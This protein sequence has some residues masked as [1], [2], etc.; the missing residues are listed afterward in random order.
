MNDNHL[1]E[2]VFSGTDALVLGCLDRVGEITYREA[3][4]L[5]AVRERQARATAQVIN[6]IIKF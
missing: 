6:E 4:E 1:D 2:I 5:Y 3:L